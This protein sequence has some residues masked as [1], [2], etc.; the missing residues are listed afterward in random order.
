MVNEK[1][2]IKQLKTAETTND[3]SDKYSHQKKKN[4]GN[5]QQQ[6]R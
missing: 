2:L 5:E 3:Q 6:T 1:Q 4:Y